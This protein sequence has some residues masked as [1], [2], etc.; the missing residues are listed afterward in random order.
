MS[1]YRIGV[2]MST[3]KSKLATLGV[4][5]L[6]EELSKMGVTVVEVS[7]IPM[8]E[9]NVK[10]IKLAIEDFGIDV[11][12]MSAVIDPLMPGMGGEC[13]ANDYD[14]IVADCRAVNCNFLRIGMMPMPLLNGTKEDIVKFA[15]R[16]E[17][18]A[19]RLKADGIELYYHNH[20][21]EFK[22][23]EGET[24]LDILRDNAPTLGFELDIHWIQ[25]GGYNPVEV[26]NAYAGRIRLLHLKDYRIGSVVMPKGFDFGAFFKAFTD[27]VEF[28]E[29]GEGSLDIPACIEAGIKGGAEYF[30]IEQDNSYGKDPLE[31]LQL[32]KDNLTKMGYG[33]WF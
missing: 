11:A 10:E 28:A 15:K 17:E 21:C 23:V 2:Q 25:R 29:V 8:T 19:T 24:I 1:K 5:G 9:Q 18:F 27:T 13:L 16:A 30:L 12:A 14:K 3:V 22:K 20:H 7:Q 32:S 26:I 31:C 33:D 4:Y 6:F